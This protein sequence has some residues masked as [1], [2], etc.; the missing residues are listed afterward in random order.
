MLATHGSNVISN[1]RKRISSLLAPCTQEEADSRIFLHV[2]QASSEGHVKI[3]IRCN[4]AD[5]VIIAAH[6]FGRLQLQE[7]WIHSG[8]NSKSKS[9]CNIR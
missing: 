5:I 8:L 1:P 6:L 2:A 9:S 3:S 4:D 7:L